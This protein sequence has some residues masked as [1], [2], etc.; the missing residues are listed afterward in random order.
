[1][2]HRYER[3][4]VDIAK[5]YAHFNLI[6]KQRDC[7]FCSCAMLVV[8]DT[9][10]KCQLVWQCA[11]CGISKGLTMN[12]PLCYIDIKLFDITIH[13]YCDNVW[14]RLAKN[15]IDTKHHIGDYFNLIRKVCSTFI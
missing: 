5:D 15:I 11:R 12:T 6:H 13:L 3:D 2:D 9:F 10:T 4:V 14:S 8:R 1:M 7:P